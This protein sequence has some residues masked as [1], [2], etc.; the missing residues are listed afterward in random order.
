MEK[1]KETKNWLE[2]T[3]TGIAS[4]LVLFTFTFLIYELIYE[5]Q[6]PPDIQISLGDVSQK[7]QGYSIPVSVKNNGSRTAKDIVVEITSE[8]NGLLEK[9][10]INFQY[11]PGKSSVHGW[12]NFTE[13]PTP[14]NLKTQVLG[15]STP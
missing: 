14:R 4:I 9:G 10:Q 11:L 13:R 3:V 7:D 1:K 12:V 2:W 6:T 15:Y 8:E 5:E